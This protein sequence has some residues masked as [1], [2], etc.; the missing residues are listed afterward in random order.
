MSYV[1]L[2]E[3]LTILS[4]NIFAHKNHPQ[5]VFLCQILIVLYDFMRIFLLYIILPNP[6]ATD[7]FSFAVLS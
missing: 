2:N 3:P 5:P 6:L 7:I 1:R 4:K